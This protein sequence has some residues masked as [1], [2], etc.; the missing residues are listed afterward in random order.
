M[1]ENTY[2]GKFWRKPKNSTPPMWGVG[3]GPENPRKRLFF[4]LRGHFTGKRH[5]EK[6][7]FR[8]GFTTIKLGQKSK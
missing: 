3:G 1:F 6:N 7:D 8:S 4:E 5:V 2:V